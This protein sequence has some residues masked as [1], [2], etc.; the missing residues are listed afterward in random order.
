MRPPLGERPAACSPT[1]YVKFSPRMTRRFYCMLLVLQP[2]HALATGAGRALFARAMEL[3]VYVTAEADRR[4]LMLLATAV[5]EEAAAAERTPQWPQ[6]KTQL[7]QRWRLLATT[8]TTGSDMLQ[9]MGRQPALGTFFVTQEWTQ[10]EEELRC[11]NK[12]NIGR[13]NA[14]ALSAWTLLPVGG[15]TALTLQHTARI[16]EDGTASTPLRM[17]ITLDGLLLD[18]NRR[19]GEAAETIFSM[20]LPPELPRPLPALLRPPPIP[21]PDFAADSIREVGTFEVTYLDELLR[22]VR[23]VGGDAA[24]LRVFARDVGT[25][26]LPTW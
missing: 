25:G 13:P 17:C 3:P 24:T 14:G 18:G 1:A 11:N 15:Q 26:E 12:V 22:I 10:R 21:V 16:V 8:Q 23:G 2:S 7:C 6:C 5:E 19:A 9:Q 20:P 4:E